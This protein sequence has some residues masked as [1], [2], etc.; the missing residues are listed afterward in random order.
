MAIQKYPYIIKK[1]DW[2]DYISRGESSVIFHFKVF[3]PNRHIWSYEE[4]GDIN[5]VAFDEKNKKVYPLLIDL[6]AD[7]NNGNSM[8]EAIKNSDIEIFFVVPPY[9]PPGKYFVQV[10]TQQ[11]SEIT[12]RFFN[13]MHTI[14]TDKHELSFTIL[15]TEPYIISTLDNPNSIKEI[16]ASTLK[17]PEEESDENN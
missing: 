15:D 8:H 6:I 11:T 5:L 3:M 1:I 17:W 13:S 4:G 7:T 16:D 14:P 12:N 2:Y 10:K 9:L